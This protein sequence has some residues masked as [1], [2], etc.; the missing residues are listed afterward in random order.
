[1]YSSRIQ[2]W[3]RTFSV[4]RLCLVIE[5]FFFSSS[6][7]IDFTQSNLYQGE[8]TFGGHSLHHLQPVI[9][10]PY[11]KVK[12]FFILRKKGSKTKEKMKEEEK[13]KGDDGPPTQKSFFVWQ[14]L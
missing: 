3:G 8:R 10:N 6:S 14:N 4:L 13:E 12:Y 2:G 7:A 9:S 1:M 5:E 11:Q